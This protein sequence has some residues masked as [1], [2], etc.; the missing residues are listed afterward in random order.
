MYSLEMND[1]QLMQRVISSLLK[2]DNRLLRELNLTPEHLEAIEKFKRYLRTKKHFIDYKSRSV[3]Q[4]IQ[5]M[6]AA[7]DDGYKGFV[8]D[9][10]Q[11]M[12]CASKNSREQEVAGMTRALKEAAAELDV[13]IVLLSQL[14]REHTK[15]ADTRPRMN[16]LR[17]SGA[18][19]Q[20][21][22]IIIFP[23]RPSYFHT[24]GQKVLEEMELIVAK[25]RST[26]TTTVHCQ[27]DGRY[28]SILD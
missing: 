7:V 24:D 3:T 1:V 14:S 23:Y 11:L 21:A 20:D 26:G 9:Y 22:D 6:R 19:E 25:G 2:I 8:V 13:P 5:S 16:D 12:T 27:W 28:T 10:L 18:I 17:E 15:R 4:I